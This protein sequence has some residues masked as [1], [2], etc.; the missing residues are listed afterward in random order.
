MATVTL[1]FAW[2]DGESLLAQVDV[3]DSYP[4]AVDEARTQ[5]VRAFRDAMIDAL[6]ITDTDTDDK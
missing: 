3:A 5:V 2:P 6:V 4:D 1:K